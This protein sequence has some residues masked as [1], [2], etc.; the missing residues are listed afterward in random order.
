V[1]RVRSPIGEMLVKTTIEEM[2]LW[3]EMHR[4]QELYVSMI[5]ADRLEG[6][7]ELFTEDCV[8]E[9][10]PRENADLGLPI[11]VMHCFGRAM[12]SDRITSLRKANVFE[13]HIY[14]HLTS[15]LELTRVE[16]ETVEMQSNYVVVQTLTEGDSRVYQAGRYFDKV[17]RT[18]NGWRYHRKR[19]VYDTLRV[20][21]LLVTPV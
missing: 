11:G 18:A 8:Y 5:D 17:V 15:G 1:S 10:V 7:P 13:P 20:P 14:R 9:I 2:T 21:T 12:L 6:W 19:A 4:L 3:Y 16:A